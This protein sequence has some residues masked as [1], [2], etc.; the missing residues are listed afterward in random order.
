MKFSILIVFATL[1]IGC[2]GD[3]QVSSEI[4]KAFEIVDEGLKRI[5]SKEYQEY[6]DKLEDSKNV[7]KRLI[8]QINASGNS[9]II[10]TSVEVVSYTYQIERK[11]NS[12]I[13]TL[14][15]AYSIDDKGKLK[16]TRDKT[17]V[18]RI[19]IEEKRGDELEE[20]IIAN[21]DLLNT[22]TNNAHLLKSESLDKLSGNIAATE[23]ESWAERHFLD[24]P[25]FAVIP[26]LRK[27][28]NDAIMTRVEM[29]ESLSG[30]E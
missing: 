17:G 1:L 2:R 12:I 4:E 14:E 24:M 20:I 7:E 10:D 19:M 3:S 5:Q 13:T 30:I 22:I 6:L 26:I 29:L 21:S 18:N 8:E 16:N 11:I 27:I 15:D 23:G 28:R 25:V 9:A